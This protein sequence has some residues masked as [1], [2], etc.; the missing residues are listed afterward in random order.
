MGSADSALFHSGIEVLALAIDG[1]VLAF[2][3]MPFT[4]PWFSIQHL[5]S[6]QLHNLRPVVWARSLQQYFL[7]SLC[8]A[9]PATIH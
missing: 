5:F 3:L 7:F 8:Q 9:L 1:V 4:G 6:C 2:P